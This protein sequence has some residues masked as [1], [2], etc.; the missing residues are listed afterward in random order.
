PIWWA[1]EG[2]YTLQLNP[3]TNNIIF[4]PLTVGTI[5]S[6]YDTIPLNS[7]KYARGYYHP[8]EYNVQWLFRTTTPT[9]TMEQYTFDGILNYNV[10][11]KAFY[12]WS[13][14]ITKIGLHGIVVID[15]AKQTDQASNPVD[16]AFKYLCSHNNV[17]GTLTSTMADNLDVDHPTV[18][19]FT[20]DSI[21]S[22][23]KAT[24][25]TGF[26]DHGKGVLKTHIPYL[27]TSSKN[28]EP[29]A[30]YLQSLWDYASTGNSGKWSAQQQ[31]NN[32]NP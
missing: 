16:H 18:D 11:I 26:K 20:Y 6:Y 29:T 28:D 19:W 27:Y 4:E 13:V 7:R 8:S 25:T 23:Y 9:T 21:G 22:D 31:V 10:A 2:I 14:D 32:F 3:Q 1:Q 30:F 12:P 17:N 5:Q 24:S 15:R